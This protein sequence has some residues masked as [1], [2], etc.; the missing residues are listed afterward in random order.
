METRSNLIRIVSEEEYH[1]QDWY[2]WIKE[3][4]FETIFLPLTLGEAK[5]LVRYE[6]DL[7][8]VEGCSLKNLSPCSFAHRTR[9]IYSSD[10]PNCQ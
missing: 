1:V 6:L 5:L 3:H 8:R 4:T 2:P 9:L 10:T 7:F